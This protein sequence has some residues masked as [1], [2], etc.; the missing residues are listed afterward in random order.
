MYNV[1]THFP[2][3]IQSEHGKFGEVARINSRICEDND[4]AWS[5][6][7]PNLC[8]GFDKGDNTTLGTT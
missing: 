1:Q 3:S 6:G 2:R 4:C 8:F 7:G 5:D